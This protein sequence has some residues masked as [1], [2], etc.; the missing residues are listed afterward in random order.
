MTKVNRKLDFTSF[1]NK[2]KPKKC[3]SS[4]D[5]DRKL[6]LL[7]FTKEAKI[8]NDVEVKTTKDDKTNG[9]FQEDGIFEIS[10]DQIIA[11]ELLKVLPLG[12]KNLKFTT[13]GYLCPLGYNIPCKCSNKKFG[14][15]EYVRKHLLNFHKI[16]RK[17]Q[18]PNN[19]TPIA[20][21]AYNKIAGSSP[22]T[23]KN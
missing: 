4:H 15:P 9:E 2:K 21:T 17:L 23:T 22:V 1:D 20:R 13:I 3:L 16:A 18:K 10:M 19:L 7:S 14:K 11:P 6:N 5:V 8:I 12:Q